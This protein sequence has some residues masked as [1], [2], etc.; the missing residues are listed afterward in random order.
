[1][2][3][4]QRKLQLIPNPER[5][6]RNKAPHV[7]TGEKEAMQQGGVKDVIT[8]GYYKAPRGLFLLLSQVGKDTAV[9]FQ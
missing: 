7:A 2:K 9:S 4:P 6:L 1:M 8:G 5:S 3:V